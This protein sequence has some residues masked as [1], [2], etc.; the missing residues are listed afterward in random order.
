MSGMQPVQSWPDCPAPIGNRFP[1]FG[2]DFPQAFGQAQNYWLTLLFSAVR[3]WGAWA[4]A[5][6]SS[7]LI[8]R[9]A[10]CLLRATD[11]DFNCCSCIQ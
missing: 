4:I 1:R 7:S 3:M 9:A 6:V 2:V 10:P 5:C 8:L 11:D